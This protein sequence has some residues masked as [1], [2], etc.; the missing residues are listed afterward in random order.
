MDSSPLPCIRFAEKEIL[1]FT[2]LSRSLLL[3]AVACLLLPAGGE[4]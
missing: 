4:R 3:L 2:Y 1:M